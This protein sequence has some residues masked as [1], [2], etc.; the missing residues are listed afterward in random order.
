MLQFGIIEEGWCQLSPGSDSN[1]SLP[2]IYNEHFILQTDRNMYAV[3]ERILFRAFNVSHPE[4]QKEF[5]SKVL[6]I[7]LVK[8]DGN[9]VK[10][11]KY[12]LS[13]QG[14]HGYLEIPEDLLTGNYYILSYT[15]WMRNFSPSDYTCNM[16][17]IINPY[18][19]QLEASCRTSVRISD[20]VNAK[21]QL[22]LY[23]SSRRSSWGNFIICR[24]GKD[25][26][27]P[28]E[29]VIVKISIP[30]APDDL[31]TGCCLQVVRPGVTDTISYPGLL[32]EIVSCSDPGH[33]SFVPEKRGM[34]VSGKVISGT[35]SE[36]VSEANVQLSVLGD[37]PSFFEYITGVDGKFLFVVDDME[38]RCDL[39]ISVYHKT[40]QS[41]DLVI[42]NDF[43]SDRIKFNNKPFIL[44]DLERKVTQEV[45]FIMQVSKVY[46]AGIFKSTMQGPS[47]EE[48]INFYGKPSNVVYLDDYI[49]LPT[50]EE[51]FI[52]LVPEV[53]PV[54]RKKKTQLIIKNEYYSNEILPFDPL[55]FVDYLPIK[56][57]DK[58]LNIAPS[59][60]QRVEVINDLC[61]QGQF[62]YGGILSIFTKE[63][64]LGGI[65]LPENSSF[66]N[67]QNF[68]EQDSIQFP[69]Y[70][71][72]SITE[73]NLPDFRNCLYWDPDLKIGL[74]KSTDVHFFTSDSKGEYI[75]VV[76]GIT[77][78]GEIIKG[79]CLFRVD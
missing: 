78:S 73:M 28:R 60:V 42:D 69:D 65:E 41:L 10:Q 29:E 6:Y 58:V 20:S 33:I 52:E 4:I 64:D 57:P 76:T 68:E 71:N 34:T 11:A 36:P 46:N 43:S 1:Y 13:P 21:S 56:D 16:V 45:V 47:S 7:E 24:T 2:G 53:Y 67:F 31:V 35:N 22:K 75:I 19:S 51:V 77:R 79:N 37:N 72:N 70:S 61:L 40:E 39:F 59:R 55:I 3:G 8:P 18:K 49:E 32:P 9:P 25:I 5:W 23:E 26:Y 66:L 12:P 54:I 17:R 27:H 48:N 15:K 30:E 44:N 38:G 14:A 62:F 63:R 74:S 50:L